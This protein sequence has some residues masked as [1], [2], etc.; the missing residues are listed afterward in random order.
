MT[1]EILLHPRFDS[2]VAEARNMPH[3]SLS[4]SRASTQPVVFQYPPPLP[5]SPPTHPFIHQPTPPLSRR[6]IPLR[7]SSHS[8]LP[9]PNNLLLRP[10]HPQLTPNLL[11]CHLPR[12]LLLGGSLLWRRLLHPRPCFRFGLRRR[13]LFVLFLFL[14][15]RLVSLCILPGFDLPVVGNAISM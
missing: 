9:D 11:R 14:C 3:P 1:Y 2:P 4:T 10:P 15:R 5:T 8:T 7:S 6:K 13:F 12:L